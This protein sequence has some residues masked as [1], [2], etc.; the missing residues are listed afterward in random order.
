MAFLQQIKQQIYMGMSE[1][2]LVDD[3]VEYLLSLADHFRMIVSSVNLLQDASVH[4]EFTYLLLADWIIVVSAFAADL[5][6]N[7]DCVE[8]L[9][10][11][12]TADEV[13]DH[14]GWNLPIPQLTIETTVLRP[15]IRNTV[16]CIDDGRKMVL[17]EWFV[18]SPGF[19]QSLSLARNGGYNFTQVKGIERSI[20]IV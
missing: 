7:L 20:D 10:R 18:A 8:L 17:G 11:D 6:Q 13:A 19:Q 4:Y 9:L 1:S 16:D 3:I 2:L 14:S 5:P 15:A 12:I